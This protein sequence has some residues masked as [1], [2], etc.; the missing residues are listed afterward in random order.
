MVPLH[1]PH[2]L[3]PEL[4]QV[5]QEKWQPWQKPFP[6]MKNPLLQLHVPLLRKALDLQSKQVFWLAVQ[7]WHRLEQVWQFPLESM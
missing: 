4:E 6:S 1:E 3:L 2:P 5:L 7:D